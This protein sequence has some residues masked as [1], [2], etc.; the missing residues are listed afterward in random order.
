MR[1]TLLFCF[2]LLGVLY[3]SLAQGSYEDC[4][5]RYVKPINSKIMKKVINYRRQELDGGCNIPAIVFKTRSARVFCAN[6][7]EKWVVTL[8]QQIDRR[9]VSK[10]P[11]TSKRRRPAKRN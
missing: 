9:H 2:L 8:M 5:L 1:I 11:N 3:L 4:C 6:P 7:D 10:R